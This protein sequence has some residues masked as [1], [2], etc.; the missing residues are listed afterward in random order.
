M[1]IVGHKRKEAEKFIKE[2]QLHGEA[3]VLNSPDKLIGT[4][5]EIIGILPSFEKRPLAEREKFHFRFNST[6]A[7]IVNL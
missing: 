5:G 2:Q 4:E 7:Q 3:E 1:Y 6:K